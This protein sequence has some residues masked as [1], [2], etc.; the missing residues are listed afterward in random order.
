MKLQYFCMISSLGLHVQGVLMGRETVTSSGHLIA[1]H[2]ASNSS[3]ITLRS[4]C[5]DSPGSDPCIASVKARANTFADEVWT[6]CKRWQT[7][8]REKMDVFRACQSIT[9]W[10]PAAGNERADGSVYELA[11]DYW[12]YVGIGGNKKNKTQGAEDLTP[13]LEEAFLKFKGEQ[14]D[15]V[16]EAVADHA[17]HVS[18]P[19]NGS[20]S[21]GAETAQ[22][23]AK[24]STMQESLE[25]MYDALSDAGASLA[26]HG[27][28]MLTFGV[29]ASLEAWKKEGGVLTPR[30]QV[31]LAA[32]ER[33]WQAQIKDFVGES[34]NEYAEAMGA[35]IDNITTDLSSRTKYAAAKFQSIFVDIPC[36]I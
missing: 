10:L 30:D 14:D 19:A 33:W 8:T 27:S 24:L 31:V 13:F 7:A 3:N 18:P 29:L 16:E 17:Y 32:S 23:K 21:Q 9:R 4:P 1:E 28:A 20:S 15:G 35:S 34:M 26:A 22:P 2:Y 36:N 5:V 6:L 25:S 12:K 11:L